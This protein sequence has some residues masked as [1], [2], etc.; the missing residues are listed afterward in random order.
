[1]SNF[2][3]QIAGF[4]E[5]QEQPE[6]FAHG[7]TLNRVILSIRAKI[8]WAKEQIPNPGFFKQK[9]FKS[10][11]QAGFQNQPVVTLQPD[12]KTVEREPRVLYLKLAEEC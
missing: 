2:F 10:D 9:L 5:Q 6:Q 11:Q 8:K 3:E 4:W 12:L 7:C 1:M